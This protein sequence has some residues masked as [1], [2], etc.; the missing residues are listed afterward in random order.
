M[1]DIARDLWGIPLSELCRRCYDNGGAAPMCTQCWPKRGVCVPAPLPASKCEASEQT[2]HARR[3]AQPVMRGVLDYF[4]DAIL[5]LAEIS[6][7]GSEQHHPGAP[8]HWEYS[9]S[10]DHADCAAR[11]LLDRGTKDTDGCDHSGK[12]AWRALANYQVEL[13]RADPE[14][15]VRR[16]AQR[17]AAAR[18]ER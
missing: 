18:G 13:E 11:H 9:K 15:H 5:K 4:P 16:Q 2:E 3:K 8:L 7:A 10:N 12:A 14:L 6:R 1:T 17:D